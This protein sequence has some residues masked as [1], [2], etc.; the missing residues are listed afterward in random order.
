MCILRK[1]VD[2]Q[3]G[4]NYVSKIRNLLH[5]PYHLTTIFLLRKNYSFSTNLQ[6]ITNITAPFQESSS[7]FPNMGPSG[8]IHVI[9]LRWVLKLYFRYVL[10]YENAIMNIPYL[11]VMI[12]KYLSSQYPC[13]KGYDD[14]RPQ[15][16]LFGYHID[17]SKTYR[18]SNYEIWTIPQIIQVFNN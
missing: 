9:K 5:S 17:L 8:L 6:C 7:I 13:H 10:I 12:P 18:P 4:R 2:Y 14:T 15:V 11:I 3:K 16:Q 1:S